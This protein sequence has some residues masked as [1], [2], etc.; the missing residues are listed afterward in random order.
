MPRYNYEKVKNIIENNKINDLTFKL[1]TKNKDYKTS[2][3]KLEIIDRDGYMYQKTFSSFYQS[4]K[5]NRNPLKFNKN[6]PY[7]KRNLEKYFKEID[8]Q[9]EIVDFNNKDILL[10]CRAHGSFKKDIS[11]IKRGQGCP[12]CGNKRSGTLKKTSLKE[13]KI[14]GNKI[15][16]MK[17]D[18]SKVVYENCDKKVEIICPY[19]ENFGKPLTLI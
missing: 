2:N 9:Y 13:F 16:N 5:N 3:T 10:N 14:R 4:I 12:V 11:H 19:M 1:L 18:Y 7:I 8:Y 6:N 15:H 17:F